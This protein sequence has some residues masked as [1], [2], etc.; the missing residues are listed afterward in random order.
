[1][2]FDRTNTFPRQPSLSTIDSEETRVSYRENDKPFLRKDDMASSVAFG[3]EPKRHDTLSN[4]DIGSN[5]SPPPTS[6]TALG[7]TTNVPRR[8]QYLTRVP[9]VQTRYMEML[10]HLDKI[11]RLHNIMASAFTWILLAG[12]LVIPGTYTKIQTSQ[13]FKNADN[14]N[15]S[16]VEHDIVHSIANIG[17]VWVSGFLAL[18]GT[19]GCFYLWFRWRQNYVWLINRIFL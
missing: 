11:P 7:P 16:G 14:P 5:Y 8:P 9:S 4:V 17:L 10:L 18:V 19:L 15:D 12:F 13:T 3:H 6:S 1:M 2:R